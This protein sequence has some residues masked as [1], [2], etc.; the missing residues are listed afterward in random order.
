MERG[1]L[2]EAEQCFRAADATFEQLSSISH[3]AGAWVALGDLAARRGDDVRGRAAATAM[4]PRPFRTCGSRDG[5][6]EA[7]EES[8]A[9]CRS[10]RG[11]GPALASWGGWLCC[12]PW[13]PP[14]PTAASP[15]SMAR[16][17]AC[18][19]PRPRS[20]RLLHCGKL[21]RLLLRGQGGAG[22]AH[23]RGALARARV[24]D[25]AIAPGSGRLRAR[26]RPARV[27]RR[28]RCRAGSSRA[29]PRVIWVANA[30]RGTA[31]RARPPPAP[32]RSA[33][34]EIGAGGPG[35]DL[36]RRSS[37]SKQPGTY[38]VLA[39]PVGG[40]KIQ[41]VGNVVVATAPAAPDVGDRGPASETPTLATTAALRALTTQR[42]TTAACCGLRRRRAR[43]E[44]PF[45]VTF[46]TPKLLHLRTCGPVV[47]VVER[48]APRYEDS[49]RALHPR[50][51]LRGQRPRE[52]QNRWVGS[53]SLPSE[54]FMFLVGADG[55]SAARFEGTLSV[56]EL[57]AAV[58]EHLLA[59]FQ[60]FP[61]GQTRAM[62]REHVERAARSRSAR[63]SAWTPAPGAARGRRRRLGAS[64]DGRG[65]AS[66]PPL[67]SRSSGRP[68]SSSASCSRRGPI[69]SR[70][71][72]RGAL[73]ARRRRTAVRLSRGASGDRVEL[74]LDLFARLDEEPIASAS[75]GQIHA[76]LLRTGREV[77]VKVRR[78]GIAEEVAL[79]LELLRSLTS[80]A[81]GRSKTA[82]LAPALG[83]D[84]GA[85]L[86]PLERA[87]LRRGG[88]WV[89][90]DRRRSWP[91]SSTCACRRSST[92][93]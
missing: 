48:C 34:S 80:L 93:T 2:E 63:R 16:L 78:P 62:G 60:R 71:L 70:T 6:E 81:E 7:H 66:V 86:A 49:G 1:S 83:A 31:V 17:A 36:R 59:S 4:P 51:D 69:C 44:A 88:A 18:F 37:S 40:R 19:S 46:A 72:H 24:E 26:A 89:G 85:R 68:S 20:S 55:R 14:G 82:R 43:R 10:A 65:R 77:V 53:G 13:T 33:S 90:G 32:R 73:G 57:A 47:D 87:R 35:G 56:R 9:L 54:P 22:V 11:V 84:R 91:S 15:K 3:R 52:E 27:P 45:V 61:L 29:R 50:R 41:A 21:R 58:E 30:P 42:A 76:A 12:F 67:A 74:G 79:D 23:A 8:F 64:R 5:K 39:E 75:I 25:V 38:W 28:R 92:R